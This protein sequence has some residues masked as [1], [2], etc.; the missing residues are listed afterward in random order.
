VNCPCLELAPPFGL[1]TIPW[2]LKRRGLTE[3]VLEWSRSVLI[4]VLF[5]LAG[6]LAEV[7]R[8]IATQRLLQDLSVDPLVALSALSPVSVFSF[9]LGYH[10]LLKMAKYWV[11]RLSS[12]S[13][14]A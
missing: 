14:W 13:D 9:S 11:G 5:Q 12:G 8:L 2:I 10:P 7:A 1:V 4:G 3:V 6:S